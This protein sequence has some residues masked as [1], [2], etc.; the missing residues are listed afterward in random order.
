MTNGEIQH[1]LA[2][3]H[4]PFESLRTSRRQRPDDAAAS[5]HRIRARPR[6]SGR[7]ARTGRTHLLESARH[8]VSIDGN[9]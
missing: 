1:R 6:A 7:W 2:S 5:E 9:P 8:D 3:V 4:P